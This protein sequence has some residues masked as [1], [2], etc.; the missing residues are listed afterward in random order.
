MKKLFLGIAATALLLVGCGETGT[1]SSNGG[2]AG[3]NSS[4]S[5]QSNNITEATEVVIGQVYSI[6]DLCEFTVNYAELKKE[7]LPPNPASFYS[8]YSEEDGSTYLD[9]SVSIKNTRTT[10]RVADDFGSIKII[11]GDGYEYSTFS[12][13]EDNNGGDFTYTNITNIDP[14]ATGVIHYIGSI[15]NELADDT[16][17]PIILEISILDNNYTMKVR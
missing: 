12:T 2:T 4:I 10:A 15:P 8:Y 3:D 7:V 6:P 9:I 13:I 16:S 11:C 1:V 5:S 14:L 17:S